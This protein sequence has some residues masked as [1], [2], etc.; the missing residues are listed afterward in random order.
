MKWNPTRREFLQAG[1]LAAVAQ[2]PARI[3][4]SVDDESGFELRLARLELRRGLERLRLGAEVRF[5]D[6]AARPAQNELLLSLRTDPNRFRDSQSYEI[7]GAGDAVTLLAAGPQ[8]LLYSVF[9]FLERQGAFFGIDGESYPLEAPGRLLLPLDGRSWKAA[10]RFAV[11]GLLPWPD[12]LN[13]ITVYNDEDFQAY[14][15]AMLRMRFNLFGMHVYTGARQWA[16]SYL[17]FEFGG[18]G[19]L[20]FLDTTAT[21][22]WGYLP[23]RT[24]S[25]GMGAADYYDAEVF[26]SDAARLARDPWEAA[27][28]ARNLLR[29]A[30]AWARRLGIRT[31]IGFEPYQIPDEIWRALPPEVRPAELP[32][33]RTAGPRFDIESVTARKLLEARLGSLLEAYPDV[34]YVWLWEDEQMNWESRRTGI[35]LSVTPF[36]QA[37]DFL[38]RH[39]PAKRLVVSGWGGV[40]RHFE[41]FHNKLPGDIIFSCLSD[42]L[43]WDPVHEVFGKLGERERWPIPWLEDDPGMWQA[44]FHVHRFERD[45]NLAAQYGCQG[46]LGIHWRHRIVDPTAGYFARSLWDASL[47]PAGYYQAYAATQ[48]AGERA[49][50]LAKLLADIDRNR[51]LLSTFTGE[52]KDGHAVTRQ[53]SGDYNEAFTFWSGYEPEPDVIASQKEVLAEFRRLAAAA[54]SPLERERLVYLAGHVEFLVPY[55]EAWTLAARIHRVLDKAAGLKKSGAASEARQ[56]VAAEAVP[57]WLR[58]AGEVRAAMLAF[59]RI[60]ATR[61]DLGTLASKHNKFV[62][63]ALYRLPLSIQEYLGE[64]PEAMTRRLAEVVQPDPDAPSRLFLPT[65]PG[66]LE[67]ARS[68]RLTLVLAGRAAPERVSVLWRR[69][70]EPGWQTLPAELAG[71]RTYRTVLGPFPAGGAIIEYFAQARTQAGEV[72]APEGA[73]ANTFLLSVI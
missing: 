38:R 61:N 40:A 47:Q 66:L 26:G 15:E 10:P 39:A 31:G 42:S 28:L 64:M 14:F 21:H 23:Q 50:R 65:R 37:H 6:P 55:A 11:R 27:E 24:S 8:A 17:S 4:I 22:R 48:A 73:P 20:A 63:L 57:L 2:T 35:P 29:K 67:H 60:V 7:V 52:F 71:R 45:V 46:M 25:F 69:L 59:Q 36:L 58:L 18:A 32:D 30:F 3:L 16:E 62:R 12:F 51:K 9:D 56:L 43:G 70:G 54:A 1:A 5:A 34:D 19:H 13:C 44:Q 33:R 72:T 53:F 68:T 41:H 49:G